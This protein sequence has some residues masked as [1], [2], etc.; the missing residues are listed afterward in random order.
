[1]ANDSSQNRPNDWTGPFF[2]SDQNT[3]KTTISGYDFVPDLVKPGR[4]PLKSTKKEYPLWAPDSDGITAKYTFSKHSDVV[5]TYTNLQGGINELGGAISNAAIF[6]ALGGF[7]NPIVTQIGSS[8]INN[9][10]GDTNNYATSPFW[11]LEK[12]SFLGVTHKHYDFRTNTGLLSTIRLDGAGAA[13]NNIINNIGGAT[14]GDDIKNSII[15][16]TYAAA[17]ATPGG[18]YK[19]FNLETM[20]G[21]G[22]HGNPDA[23]RLDFTARSFISTNWNLKLNEGRGGWV[24]T[25]N[26]IEAATPFRGDKIN[27]IDYSKRK[28]N[29][30]YR[31]KPNF[32][33]NETLNKITDVLNEFDL[34]RDFIKFY[35]TGPKLNAGNTAEIDDIIVFRATFSEITDQHNPEWGNVRMIGRAD[36]N[37]VYNGYSRD[38]SLSFTIY[39]TD[40]DEL[41][42]IY[43]KLNYLASYTTPEYSDET[44]ALKG[45]WM[46]VTIGDLLVQQPVII[47]SLSYTFGGDDSPWEI[48]IENDATNMQV[49]FKIS[50][51]IS[52]NVISDYLP[53]KGG[54]FYTLAK[55]FNGTTAIP[56]Q[57]SDDWLS[58]SKTSQEAI[59]KQ[60]K[61][62]SQQADKN[63]DTVPKTNVLSN[64]VNEDLSLVSSNT[65]TAAQANLINAGGLA[66]LN[67]I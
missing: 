10:T 65:A 3:P 28:L 40:R 53:Q 35:F 58:D 29:D 17:S 48:N 32:T 59:D 38:L 12:Q 5:S 50:V 56:K 15:A 22:D 33:G 57:G 9:G 51:Q 16:A 47:N 21:W 25:K 36:D 54:R 52:L 63:V 26:P 66:S 44:I 30:I 18:A 23:V 43:R 2:V 7:G 60:R 42:P 20:Y 37:Y 46:R 61:F 27:V 34:T 8:I 62:E 64:F 11:N 1:M 39:A 41:K 6:G 4:S 19:I 31:W 24:R 55:S 13:V 45:P 49:P 67:R 14:S